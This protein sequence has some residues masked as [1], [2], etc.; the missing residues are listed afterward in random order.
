MLK[1]LTSFVTKILSFTVIFVARGS[2]GVPSP[3]GV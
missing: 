2:K 1:L 3:K